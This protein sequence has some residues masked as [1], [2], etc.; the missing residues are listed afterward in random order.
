MTIRINNLSLGL[1]EDISILKK[2]AS[3]KL[4]ISEN[5]IKDLKK[6]DTPTQYSSCSQHI[7]KLIL[8]YMII[9]IV[10]DLVVFVIW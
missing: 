10:F 4:R 8:D 9:Q 1:D 5:E 2:K 7:L 3:K 6:W